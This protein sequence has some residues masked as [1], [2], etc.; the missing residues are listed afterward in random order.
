MPGHDHSIELQNLPLEAEQ[1]IAKRGKAHTANLR[2]LAH[3]TRLQYR[4]A[5][6][7]AVRALALLGENIPGRPSQLQVLA[8]LARTKLALVGKH[9]D[10]MLALPRMTNPQKLA[11]MRILMLATAPAYFEDQNLLPLLA[12][13]MV[14]LSARFGNAAHSAYGYVMYGLVHCGVLNDMPGGLAYGQLALKAIELFDARDIRGRISMVLGGFILHWNGRLSDTLPHFSDGANASLEAGDLEFHGYNRYAFASYAFMSGTPLDKVADLLDEGY[15]AVLEHKHEKTQRVFR[16]A[17]QAVRELR[18]VGAK[19]IEEEIPFDEAAEVI[20]WTERD[21]MALA[22]YYKYR[23]LKQFMARDLEGCVASARVIDENFNV[24]MGMAF[25]AYYMPYQ[26]LALIGLLPKMAGGARLAAMRT[27]RR[28]QRRL[29]TWSRHAPENY[30]HKWVLVNAE[31]ARLRGRELEAER[32]YQE[33]IQLASRHGA[34]PDEAL[35]HELAGEFELARGRAT[36]GR[37]HL[38]EARD[39]YSHWGSLAWVDHLE[40]RHP[41]VIR[42]ERDKGAST[43]SMTAMY[44]SETKGLVDVAAITRAANAISGKT[45]VKDVAAE[46]IEASVMN[47][48]ATRGLLLLAHGNELVIHGESSGSG[49]VDPSHA[50]PFAGSGRGP[51]RLV[52]YVARTRESI[53]LDDATRDETYGEDPFI[54]ERRPLSALCMPLLDRGE[55]VGLLYAENSLTRGAFTADRIH[56]LQLLAS[57]AA[58]SLENARLFQEIRSHANALE[59]KVKERTRELEDA[60]GMLREIFGKYVPRGVAEAI[61]AGRGSL[62]P[63]QTLA[64]IF[65]SDIQ[66]FTSI[67][68]HIEPGRLFDMLNEYFQILIEPIERNGGIVNQFL[69]DAML[70]TFNI[71]IADPQHAQKAVRTA[72]EIQRVLQGR[73]FAGVELVTRI[74]I[75]TGMVITG[76]VG[77]GKR[78]HYA[79]YGDAVNLAARL[80]QLNKDYGTRVLISGATKE[81][82]NGAYELAPVGEVVVRGKTVPVKLYRLDIPS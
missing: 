41:E 14:R 38:F 28:N 70:V 71:P 56:T 25:S 69:G 62:R 54:V 8:E 23:I 19:A 30:L 22:Y 61:V 27:I 76:N 36:S 18:G 66:G 73:K 57:Q 58:I 50:L 17:R 12:L 39:A 35:A 42:V 1:L 64:T 67:V 79:V 11:A 15:A 44:S 24:V 31:L 3:T 43:A 74:G 33:A 40:R 72:A 21:R 4:K 37:A 75:H 16:M 80:E 26:S 6:E 46:V 13:R 49:R 65:Y 53:V 52:N 2:H 51:E 81:L 60:Y 7:T 29:R 47:A 48:G 34:L 59:V 82:L 9:P 32:A 55:L 63:T 77:S 78:V 20:Y 5:I 45:L 10:D 68:E